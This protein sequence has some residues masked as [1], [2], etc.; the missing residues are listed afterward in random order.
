MKILV[1]AKAL[2]EVLQALTGP[3]HLIR[4]LQVT[5]GSELFEN[6]I[7]KLVMDFQA[8]VMDDSVRIDSFQV[9]VTLW[10]KKCFGEVIAADTPERNYRFLE[11]ALEL[12]QSKGCTAEDAHKLVDYVFGRPVGDPAQEVGGVM[13]T[14]AALCQAAGLPMAACAVEEYRRINAPEMIERIRQ[15]QATKPHRSPLPGA[16]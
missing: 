12:V 5:R 1:D 16:A 15:K 2:Q 7:D 14:L 6:P 4:E 3:G 11:E 9:A 8:Y 13:V 10:M